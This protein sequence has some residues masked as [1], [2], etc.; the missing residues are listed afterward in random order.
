MGVWTEI[1]LE[2]VFYTECQK[3]MADQLPGNSGHLKDLNDSPDHLGSI[4]YHW[5]G[6][7]VRNGKNSSWPVTSLGTKGP[8]KL[9]NGTKLI[10]GNNLFRIT[11]ESFRS[12][13]GPLL[14][15][16]VTGEE[17][18]FAVS[19]SKHAL[20]AF[21]KFSMPPTSNWLG[22]FVCHLVWVTPLYSLII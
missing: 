15:K 11:L 7:A 16:P 22:T 18:F 2:P 5:S 3:K 1:Q 21:R 12:F 10:L 6:F 8:L 4:E 14:Y 13:R 20:R 9:L 19:Y 17:L